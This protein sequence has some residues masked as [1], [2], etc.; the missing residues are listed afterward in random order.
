MRQSM[1]AK[2]GL[3][4]M[5]VER[6]PKRNFIAVPPVEAVISRYEQNNPGV[7]Y[8]WVANQAHWHHL[9]HLATRA[10]IAMAVQLGLEKPA[11]K[12]AA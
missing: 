4:G 2:K 6:K 9:R 12:A 10:E 3:N 11:A 1:R 8:T 5:Q 7:K